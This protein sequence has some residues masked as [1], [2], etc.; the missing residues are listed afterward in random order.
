MKKYE[1]VKESWKKRNPSNVLPEKLYNQTWETIRKSQKLYP[2]R[3]MVVNYDEFNANHEKVMQGVFAFLN[4][5]W[6]STFLTMAPLDAKVAKFGRVK[7][8]P[9]ETNA[10]TPDRTFHKKARMSSSG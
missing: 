4:M 9:A 7:S 2:D 6:N 3:V 5:E 1:D 10:H 8:R